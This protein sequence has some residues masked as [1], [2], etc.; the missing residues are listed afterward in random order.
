[1][2]AITVGG[3]PAFIKKGS[4][5]E[6]TRENNLFDSS[7]GYTLEMEFPLVDCP[8]NVEAF[9][10]LHLPFTD[11]PTDLIPCTIQCG[12][13]RLVGS[14]SIMNVSEFAVK[15]QFLEGVDVSESEKRLENSFINEMDLGSYYQTEPRFLNPAFS[16]WQS[17]NNGCFLPWTSTQYEV[18]N[19]KCMTAINPD[20]FPPIYVAWYLTTSYITWQPMLVDIIRKVASNIGYSLSPSFN[21][22]LEQQP[23]WNDAVICN[24]LPFSWRMPQ[25]ADALPHWNVLEFFEKL[26]YLFNGSFEFDHVEKTIT[27]GAFENLVL[28]AGSVVIDKVISQYNCTISRDEEDADYLPAKKLRYKDSDEQI[29]KYWCCPQF[30]KNQLENNRDS[31]QIY[32]TWEDAKP[33][34][35][36]FTNYQS[37]KHKD[38]FTENVI[39]IKDLDTYF[40]MR[41]N[42]AKSEA[43]GLVKDDK[44]VTDKYVVFA[45]MTP[46]NIFGP[47]AEDYDENAPYTELDIVPVIIDWTD[48]G[49]MMILPVSTLD[50]DT[51]GESSLPG[52]SSDS[53]YNS[54]DGDYSYWVT[55]DPAFVQKRSQQYLE[56]GE[57]DKAEYFDRIYLGFRYRDTADPFFPNSTCAPPDFKIQLSTISALEN[58]GMMRLSKGKYGKDISKIN[59]KVMFEFSFFASRMPDIN[60]TF[61]INGRKFVCRRLTATFSDSGISEI[62]K[63]QFYPVS[64]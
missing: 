64:D 31:I 27:F 18:V 57:S 60:A 36:R 35:D 41:A 8:Q 48:Y 51:E 26:G 14:I 46:I 7:E 58:R 54:S 20:F 43:V 21:E 55:S 9:G 42:F 10:L 52:G 63:G 62:M 1:M 38:K 5:F 16:L 6:F 15:A 3:K 24:T 22:F 53:G 25:Y 37:F 40:M 23:K 39:Y 29:W 49:Q 47:D 19:N 45:Q 30:L 28:K 50:D 61:F 12:L 34:I 33:N 13:F 2:I 11:K 17:S 56:K 4:S 44:I 59:S 32:E